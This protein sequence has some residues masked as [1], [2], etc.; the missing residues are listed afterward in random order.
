MT[1]TPTPAAGPPPNLCPTC[2]YYMAPVGGAS[3]GTCHRY[4]PAGPASPATRWP[5]VEADEWCGEYQ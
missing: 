4:P 3:A 5:L 1:A 2:R